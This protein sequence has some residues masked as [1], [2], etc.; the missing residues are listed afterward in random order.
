MPN[1]FYI[2]FTFLRSKVR[3]KITGQNQR[4]NVWRA[5]VAIE[6]SALPSAAIRA[7]RVISSLLIKG[8]SAFIRANPF[9]KVV[10]I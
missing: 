7:I 10:L 4:S 1:F 9:E 2:V 3:L 6:G 8:Q 5:A